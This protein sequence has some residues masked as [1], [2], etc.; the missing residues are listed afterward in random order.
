MNAKTVIAFIAGVTIGSLVTW[1]FV[2]TKYKQIA[3]EEIK[4]VVERF[5][6]PQDAGAA[7]LDG[8]TEPMEEKPWRVE[9]PDIMEY[10]ARIKEARYALDLHDAK[11]EKEEGGDES[12]DSDKPYVISPEEFDELD[13]YE[14]RSFTYYEDGILTDEENH[15][16]E[17]VDEL[18][19]KDSLDTFG[20]YEQDSVF[21]R[22]DALK[23][24]FEILRDVRNYTDVHTMPHLEDE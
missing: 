14:I 5:T 18:V 8:Q 4:S 2:E 12:M 1:K 22:N 3:D 10:A 17:N 6:T 11:N 15:I 13:D 9:K 24:D 21:V 16:V 20:Y 7:A 23:T 19:G